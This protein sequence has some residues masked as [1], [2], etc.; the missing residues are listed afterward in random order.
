MRLWVSKRKCEE[1]TNTTQW[2]E[3]AAPGKGRAT[4]I[5]SFPNLRDHTFLGCKQ[6]V[7][8]INVNSS[9]GAHI[10]TEG[11]ETGNGQSL[12]T[13]HPSAQAHVAIQ[14]SSHSHKG[15]KI[16]INNLR[17]TFQPAWQEE[18]MYKKHTRGALFLKSTPKWK[19]FYHMLFDLLWKALDFPLLP[20][21]RYLKGRVPEE[22]SKLPWRTKAKVQ[23]VKR[24]QSQGRTNKCASRRD[25]GSPSAPLCHRHHGRS[26][27]HPSISSLQFTTIDLFLA[28]V[29]WNMFPVLDQ[30]DKCVCTTP[31]YDDG[32]SQFLHWWFQ[33]SVWLRSKGLA[34]QWSYGKC[35]THTQ[36]FEH[37]LSA[38]SNFIPELTTLPNLREPKRTAVH[39]GRSFRLSKRIVRRARQQQC[40][41]SSYHCATCINMVS[42][43]NFTMGAFFFTMIKGSN[44]KR[45]GGRIKEDT[46]T[47][48]WPHTHAVT[49]HVLPRKQEHIHTCTPHINVLKYNK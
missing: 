2:A 9:C 37:N 17:N 48:L 3:P 40:T 29:S 26:I 34:E 8:I 12:H 39:Q 11:R 21:K 14:E 38:R 19:A 4:C 47:K 27:R 5:P 31:E 13:T 10:M 30:P 32:N 43:I 23:K 49:T 46:C 45:G 22:L 41:Y 44:W 15:V 7:L 36:K 6:R 1:V 28:F 42:T 25:H 35:P 20:N 33:L 24:A 18:T 16:L